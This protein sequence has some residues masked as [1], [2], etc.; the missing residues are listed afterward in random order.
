MSKKAV[1]DKALKLIDQHLGE[2]ELKGAL[3]DKDAQ[4][5]L[6]AFQLTKV[7]EE[8]LDDDLDDRSTEELEGIIKAEEEGRILVVETRRD[9]VPPSE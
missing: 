9:Q 2:L 8:D 6:S 1:N 5:V 4:F 7:D 3:S